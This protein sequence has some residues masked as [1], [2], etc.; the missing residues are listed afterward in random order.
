MEE[1]RF[2]VGRVDNSQSSSWK[3]WT[4][5]NETYLLQ[6]GI[7]AKHHNF[8]FHSTGNCLWAEINPK[9]RG[10]ERAILEWSRDPVPE[11][12]SGQGCLLV[13]MTFPTSHLSAPRATK[14]GNFSWI[15]PA[16]PDRAVHV[17][18]VLTQ[19]GRTT[20]EMLFGASGHRQLLAYLKLRNGMHICAAASI[21]RARCTVDGSW[22]T[23]IARP[24]FRRSL[25]S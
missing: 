20:V 1:Y 16:P 10:S 3:L 6:R 25:P 5:G 18:V 17:E 23:P 8:S 21:V 24:D 12:G 4:Q 15:D 9:L 11:V 19:E 7:S 2:A 22:K 14:F 13:S